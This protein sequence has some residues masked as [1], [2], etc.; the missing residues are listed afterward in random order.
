MCCHMV[1]GAV[2]TLI[3]LHCTSVHR[4]G[5]GAGQ[6]VVNS[7]ALVAASV[8]VP[9]SRH[10]AGKLGFACEVLIVCCRVLRMVPVQV[11]LL[12][13]HA[14]QC[15][16]VCCGKSAWAPSSGWLRTCCLLLRR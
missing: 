7:S 14:C 5:V 1:S 15:W 10:K 2:S 8:R 16:A 12:S 11:S 13:L 3:C 9:V 6:Q 4:F